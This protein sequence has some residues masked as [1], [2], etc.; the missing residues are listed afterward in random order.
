[1]VSRNEV[2]LR[3]FKFVSK[4]YDENIIQMEERKKQVKRMEEKDRKTYKI[5]VVLNRVIIVGLILFVLCHL[6]N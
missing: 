2:D 5:V 3:L 4:K 1:V 6:K